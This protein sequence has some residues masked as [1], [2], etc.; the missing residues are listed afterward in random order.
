LAEHLMKK[1]ALPG[2]EVP[3]IT[4][5]L[6][7]AM[8]THPWPGNVRELE[9][10]VRKLLI[11]GNPSLLARD[12]RAKATRKSLAPAF[13]SA[14]VGAPET[15]MLEQA[16]RAKDQAEKQAILATLNATRWN[17]RQA[18][19]LLQVD[20]KALLY[21]MKKLDI[22]EKRLSNTVIPPDR[23]QFSA[24]SSVA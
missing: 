12:L 9:N 19:M 16:S 10:L 11:L 13:R 17:R 21:K 1:H 14:P 7:Q 4:P 3:V 5:E 8:L 24:S 15:G 23:F 20:Y 6:Q 22:D 18:A 2:V